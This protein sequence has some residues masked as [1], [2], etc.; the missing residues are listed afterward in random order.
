MNT[1]EIDRL[2]ERLLDARDQRTWTAEIAR[3]MPAAIAELARGEPVDVEGLASHAGL[4]VADVLEFL[5]SSPAEFD[6]DGRLVGFGLTLRPTAHRFELDGRTLYTWCAPDALAFPVVLGKRA[7]IES[8]CLATGETIRIELDP[9]GVRH[10]DPEEAVVSIVT[11]DV[12][13]SEFRRRLCDQQHFFKSAA[14][15]AGWLAE[16]PAA[17]VV[18]VRDG[19]TRTRSLLPGWLGAE[20]AHGSAA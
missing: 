5:H 4:P 12:S 2:A 11:P 20:S 16:R 3:I 14:A 13:L 7:R 19:F 8:P 6:D 1:V 15:A 17:I 10:V 9:D 18:P